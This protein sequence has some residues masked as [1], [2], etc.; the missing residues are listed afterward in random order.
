VA[1]PEYTDANVE[2]V[3]ALLQAVKGDTDVD[4]TT[5]GTVG[6]K[7]YDGFMYAIRK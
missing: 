2:G 7:G 5:I 4:A 1:I 6:D 3:R